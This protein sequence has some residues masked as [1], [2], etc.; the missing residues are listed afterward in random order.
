MWILNQLKNVEEYS[1][2]FIKS[3]SAFDREFRPEKSAYIRYDL[4]SSLYINSYGIFQSTYIFRRKTEPDFKKNNMTRRLKKKHYY[5][6]LLEHT[7]WR[8]QPEIDLILLKNVEGV[9]N[10]GEVVKIPRLKA[11]EYFILTGAATFATPENL[12]KHA[13]L[14][15]EDAI[16]VDIQNVCLLRLITLI[17]PQ[18]Y[19]INKYIYFPDI[20]K[21]KYGACTCYYAQD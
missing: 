7:H 9:G 13:I 17:Q 4:L 20:K 14:K 5:Y 19:L 8:K 15:K 2:G 6:T 16:P 10:T 1:G 21:V 12:T 3:P 11:Y 18:G